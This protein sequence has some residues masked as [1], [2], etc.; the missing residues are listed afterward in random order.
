MN[1]FLMRSEFMSLDFIEVSTVPLDERR[2]RT[3]GL[4]PK[5]HIY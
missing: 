5:G 2:M 1:F 4:L 3:G